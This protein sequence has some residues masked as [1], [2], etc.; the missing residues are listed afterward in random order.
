MQ[1]V[2]SGLLGA[3]AVTIDGDVVDHAMYQVINNSTIIVI[4]PP[5][6]AGTVPIT[7]TTPGGASTAYAYARAE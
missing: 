6:A 5:G 7:V 2:G 3:T 1:I 4:L